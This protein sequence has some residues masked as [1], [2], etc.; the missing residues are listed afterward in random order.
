M[1]WLHTGDLARVDDEGYY[2]IAGRQKE[3]LI[4]GGVNIYPAEIESA[5]L[6]H[7][8]IA[9]AAVVPMPDPQ[10]GE[11]PAA[12]VVVRVPLSSA[13]ILDFL[14]ARL[15]RYKLPKRIELLAD[16]P[17]TSSGTATWEL[18]P[19]PSRRAGASREPIRMHSRLK[20]IAARQRP[21]PPDISAMKLCR[22]KY[23]HA[24]GR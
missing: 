1:G 19:K 21:S 15:A 3:M 23:L 2:S 6:N 18:L 5:L 17:R 4:S 14:G 22:S 24:K 8:A 16:L 12:F 20:A 13:E 10:W 11:V 9:A 7:P